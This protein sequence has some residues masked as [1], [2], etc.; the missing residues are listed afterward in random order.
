MKQAQIIPLLIYV[1]LILI[2]LWVSTKFK[3]GW[4]TK[5]IDVK[6]GKINIL[7]FIV[8]F[9]FVLAVIVKTTM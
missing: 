8:L 2:Y 4:A 7:L 1:A 3:R 5:S 9:F 6:G